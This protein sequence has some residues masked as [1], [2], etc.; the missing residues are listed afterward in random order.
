MIYTHMVNRG[1]GA[2][3]SPTDRLPPGPPRPAEARGE[4]DPTDYADRGSRGRAATPTRA[5]PTEEGT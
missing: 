5:R 2:V 3:R 1:P 4:L